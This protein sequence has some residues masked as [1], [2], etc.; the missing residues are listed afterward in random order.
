MDG[1]GERIKA[2]R[3]LKGWSQKDTEK[4]SGVNRDTLSGI[5]SGRHEPRP[6]TLRKLATAFG[7]EVADFFRDTALPKADASP[8]SEDEERR[9][10]VFLS[11]C[12]SEEGR[13]RELKKTLDIINGYTDRWR[14][15]VGR[16]ESEGTFPYGRSIEM[17]TFWERFSDAIEND[18]IP[19]YAGWV[20]TERLE[21]SDKERETANRILNAL[22]DMSHM[23]GRMHEIE[24]KNRARAGKEAKEL[25][26]LE[27]EFAQNATGEGTTTLI[28]RKRRDALGLG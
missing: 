8:S 18:G 14:V 1:V 9:A 2:E 7:I 20:L 17:R 12:P 27:A 13:L 11:A 5:E 24:H 6:S 15:E 22:T 26:G 3:R 21:A 25:E 23:V 19:E 16:V 4:V 10:Q 28:I